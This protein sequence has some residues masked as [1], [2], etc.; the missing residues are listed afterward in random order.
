MVYWEKMVIFNIL[1][2]F[3]LAYRYAG[4]LFMVRSELY[5]LLSG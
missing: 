3:F 2:L 4:F 5:F 1:L